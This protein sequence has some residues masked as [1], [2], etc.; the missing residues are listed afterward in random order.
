[1]MVLGQPQDR[2]VS[3]RAKQCGCVAHVGDGDG[4]ERRRKERHRRDIE[5]VHQGD[6]GGGTRP[7]YLRIVADGLVGLQESQRRTLVQGE[8]EARNLALISGSD[9]VEDAAFEAAEEVAAKP[10]IL[11]DGR[12]GVF[13]LDGL[14]E[15]VKVGF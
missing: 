9:L 1:M 7:V 6:C 15:L 3:C 14:E 10:S 4:Q 2:A 11:V 12:P 13:R 5:R 8:P